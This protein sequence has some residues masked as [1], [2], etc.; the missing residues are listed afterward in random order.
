MVTPAPTGNTIVD[1]NQTVQ[2]TKRGVCENHLSQE[3]FMALGKG[4]SW[5]YNWAAN[6]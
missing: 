1:A 5:Y 4:V 2:A 6:T 3:D